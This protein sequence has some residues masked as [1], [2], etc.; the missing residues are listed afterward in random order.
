MGRAEM[1]AVDIGAASDCAHAD[2]CQGN[3]DP[4][5]MFNSKQLAK[6]DEAQSKRN[7]AVLQMLLAQLVRAHLQACGCLVDHNMLPKERQTESW[8]VFETQLLTSEA[9]ALTSRAAAGKLPADQQ[10]TD[11]QV[12]Q[13]TTRDTRQASPSRDISQ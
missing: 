2:Q 1:S 4:C 10:A 9:A 3:D 8:D 11:H 5:K 6:Y 13:N 12:I 7:R